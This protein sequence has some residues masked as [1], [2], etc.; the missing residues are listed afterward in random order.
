MIVRATPEALSKLKGVG[1]KKAVQII[2]ESRAKL[3]AK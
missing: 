1:K 3:Q 2:E